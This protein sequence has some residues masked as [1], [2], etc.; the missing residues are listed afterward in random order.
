MN[1]TSEDMEKYR[2]LYYWTIQQLPQLPYTKPKVW[3]AFTRQAPRYGLS[4]FI[5]Y[6]F[7]YWGY[8]PLLSV[9]STD[10][11]KCVDTGDP[12]PQPDGSFIQKRKNPWY[13]FTNPSARDEIIVASDLARDAGLPTDAGKVFEA[14]ILHELV[15]FCRKKAGMNVNDEGPPYAFEREAY[16]REVT[17]TWESCYSPRYFRS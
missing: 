15:H 1:L 8:P 17:R 9:N 12:E 10:M 4:G 14:T 2:D 16:G 13:G 7:F 6:P 11:M 5:A 3:A